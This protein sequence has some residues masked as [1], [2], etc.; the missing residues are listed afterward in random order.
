MPK[1][2]EGKKW[3]YNEL[4]RNTAL[5]EVREL[6][7]IDGEILTPDEAKNFDFSKELVDLSSLDFSQ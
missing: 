1:G 5:I 2:F 3:C 7:A 6:I 4:V